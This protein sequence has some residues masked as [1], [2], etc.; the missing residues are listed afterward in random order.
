MYM[1]RLI[2]TTLNIVNYIV[3][4]SHVKEDFIIEVCKVTLHR[5][6]RNL[7]NKWII[8]YIYLF[9]HVLP[10]RYHH[11]DICYNYEVMLNDS[12]YIIN[13]MYFLL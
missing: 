1:Y 6:E 9:P 8:C 5:I 4:F 12:I 7:T 2:F 13:M 3:R 11:V 10:Q